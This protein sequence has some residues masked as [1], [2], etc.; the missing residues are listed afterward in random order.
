[1]A[2]ADELHLPVS[3]HVRDAWGDFTAYLRRA[4]LNCSG[5]MHCWSGSVESAKACLDAGLY[6]SFAG[7][8][9]FANANKLL[10][11][12]KYV[13]ADR[14]LV[15]T[16]CPY[17]A[18]VP[19]RGRRNEPAFVRHT[20]EKLAQLRGISFAQLAEQTYQNAMTLFGLTD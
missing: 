13:P 20:A 15:E 16:D 6:I 1:M 12:A 17:L 9:T 14:L 5:V 2:L 8:L 18:P 10:D 4:P 19:M 7:T 3:F 11:V